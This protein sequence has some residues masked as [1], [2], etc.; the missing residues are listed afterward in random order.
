MVK[1][2][3]ND[4]CNEAN[5]HQ[6]VEVT[7]D[8]LEI[9]DQATNQTKPTL[10]PAVTTEKPKSTHSK[11]TIT[12]AKPNSKN[13]PQ[14][15][16]ISNTQIIKTNPSNKQKEGQTTN[17]CEMFEEFR[18]RVNA[19]LDEEREQ[20]SNCCT[21]MNI[22]IEQYPKISGQFVKQD[23]FNSLDTERNRHDT[24]R[25]FKLY[26]PSYGYHYCITSFQSCNKS[27]HGVSKIYDFK[28]RIRKTSSIIMHGGAME[29]S[30]FGL[31][32]KRANKLI[33]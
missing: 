3:L 32:A 26:P 6:P 22:Q 2:K 15:D 27:V 17:T 28:S 12:T 13:D 5:N 10:V 16:D 25:L 7:F 20:L 1:S 9:L 24:V 4:G 11:P 30:L 29:H 14:K 33:G 18:K 21:N 19:N 23:R 8:P 31:T